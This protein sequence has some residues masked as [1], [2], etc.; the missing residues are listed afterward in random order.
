[1]GINLLIVK[2]LYFLIIG[3]SKDIYVFDTAQNFANKVI[4]KVSARGKVAPI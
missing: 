1:M 2:E 4:Y 3:R